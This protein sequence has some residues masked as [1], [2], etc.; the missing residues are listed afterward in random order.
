L[1]V[2]PVAETITLAREASGKHRRRSSP[3]AHT[4]GVTMD[5]IASLFDVNR[6][7]IA[8]VLRARPDAR[9]KAGSSSGE[10]RRTPVDRSRRRSRR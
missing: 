2:A 9:C 4:E 6:Q 5:E 1:V 8:E 3:S 7:R 10:V